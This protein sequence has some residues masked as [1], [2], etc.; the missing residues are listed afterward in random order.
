[1]EEIKF[2]RSHFNSKN[3]LIT[4]TYWG[5]IDHTN[6]FCNTTFSSPSSVSSSVKI[7]D[8]MYSTLKDDNGV[9]IF[10]ND[11][12]EIKLYIKTTLWTHFK[13]KVVFGNY[14][15]D[16]GHDGEED[17]LGWYIDIE[18]VLINQSASTFPFNVSLR[19]WKES[20]SIKVIGN[21]HEK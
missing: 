20:S 5:K 14:T 9:E 15:T 6:E 11:I 10:S 3:E 18:K 17:H 21:I 19:D 7:V 2:R 4:F 8:D 13:G 16:F 1:M 12:V